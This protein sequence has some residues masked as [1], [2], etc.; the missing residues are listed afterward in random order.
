MANPVTS[1]ATTRAVLGAAR[2]WVYIRFFC[3]RDHRAARDW[4]DPREKPLPP[5]PALLERNHPSGMRGEEPLHDPVRQALERDHREPAARLQDAKAAV[6]GPLQL[7]DLVVHGHAERLERPRGRMVRPVP[8]HRSLDQLRQL[9]RRLDGTRRTRLHDRARDAPRVRLLAERPQNARQLRLRPR[10][11]ERRRRHIPRPIHP[12]VKR[13]VRPEAEPTA[14]FIQLRTRHAQI[15][16]NPIDFSYSFFL[17]DLRK[18]PVAPVHQHH[19]RAHHGLQPRGALRQG[20]FVA[21]NAHERRAGAAAQENLPRMAATPQRP[22]HVHAA[23]TDRQRINHLSEKNRN[24]HVPF[25]PQKRSRFRAARRF[26]AFSA[27]RPGAF[28]GAQR[29]AI[30]TA[31]FITTVPFRFAYSS[32]LSQMRMRP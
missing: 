18:R 1:S 9:A 2:P 28:S 20:L 6:Q 27:E 11:H 5:L 24:V 32:N 29:R 17:H 26:S 15:K 14:G 8:P 13:P 31:P 3:R 10:R 7:A 16:Q 30:R 21:V 19:V 25:L 4:A 23:R 22:V 12:H